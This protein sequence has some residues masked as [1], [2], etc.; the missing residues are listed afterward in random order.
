MSQPIAFFL[1]NL[2]GGGAERSVLQVASAL[3]ERGHP[4]ELVLANKSGPYVEHIPANMP[5]YDFGKENTIKSLP[6][7]RKYLATNKPR[8][9]LGALEKANVTLQLAT[10][11]LARKPK[12]IVSIRNSLGEENSVLTGRK[13]RLLLKLAKF[14]YPKASGI[15]AVSKGVATQTA[16]FLNIPIDRITVIYNPVI[17]ESLLA[18]AQGPETDLWLQPANETIVAAGRLNHQ[19]DFSTLL[20]A[21]QLVKKGGHPAKL[22]IFGEGELRTQLETEVYELGLDE[23]V[24]LPGFAQNPFPHFRAARMFV[25]SSRYEGLPGVL[26]QAMAC[27][28]PVVATNCP[29]GP[30]EIL[31]QGEL[32]ELVPVGDHV[33]LA[34]A[35]Q[36]E[37]D[38]TRQSIP[39]S[40]LAPFTQD[41][42][43][44][45]YEELLCR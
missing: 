1:P 28:A 11:G 34:A 17:N 38:R 14:L 4:V 20:R 22:I 7:L 36:R 3:L 21:F 29:S 25:L 33:N 13:D 41:T 31:E 35:I 9:V 15:H 26:I 12:V 32:G 44:S 2:E 19:K 39:L 16:Q 45:K 18:A 30:E 40:R 24:R 37:L 5:V 8:C 27:G 42:V 43:I 10:I 23:D 6:S